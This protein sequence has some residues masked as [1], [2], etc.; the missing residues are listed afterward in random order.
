MDAVPIHEAK[1]QF[2]R[3]IARAEAG[4]EII[5]RRGAK[6]V[7]NIVAYHP[8][9]TSR[10]PGALKGKLAIADDFDEPLDG[11]AAYGVDVRR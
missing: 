2:S 7:A 10:V 9:T 3:L 8:P 1:T 6:L 4:E 5:V 11:F